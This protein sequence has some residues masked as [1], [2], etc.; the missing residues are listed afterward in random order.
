MLKSLIFEI[1]NFTIQGPSVGLNAESLDLD[2]RWML[3]SEIWM[4]LDLQTFKSN[5]LKCRGMAWML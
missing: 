2:D 4:F 3:N 1:E 5:F